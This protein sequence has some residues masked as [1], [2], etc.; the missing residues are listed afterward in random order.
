MTIGYGFLPEIYRFNYVTFLG[1][2]FLTYYLKF[3]NALEEP[4]EGAI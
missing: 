3:F 1:Y 2:Y 4:N